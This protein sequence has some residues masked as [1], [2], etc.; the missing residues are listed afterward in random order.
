MSQD[1]VHLHVHSEFSLLDGLSKIKKLIEKTKEYDQ[2]A[3]GLTDH[4]S[5][6]GAINFY[7]AA[8][9]EEIKPIIGCEAYMASE[10]RFDKKRSDAYHILLLA[11]DKEGYE[12]LMKL[13][14]ISYLDGFYYKPRIDKE[15]LLKYHKGIIATTGCPSSLVNRT[16]INEGYKQG[17]KEA[18]E[19]SQIFGKENLFIELQRHHADR[20]ITKDMPEKIKND[21]THMQQQNEQLENHLLKLS[22]ELSLPLI[23]TN[24]VHYVNKED[25]TAQD[26]VVCVQTGKLVSEINRMR[27]IDVPDYYLKSPEEM[28][29]NFSDLPEAI[30]NTGKISDRINLEI[31][32]GQWFFPKYKLPKGKTAGETLKELSYSGAKDLFKEVTDELKK[33]LDYELDIIETK[34]YSP[35]FLIYSDLAKAST[36]MGIY[37]NTRGSAAGSLVSYCCGITTVDPLRFDLPFERFLN[38]LRPSAPDIDFDVSDD[39][40]DLIIHYLK[41]KYGI[42]KVAQICTF[43]TMKA[44]AAIRDIGRVLGY[45]YSDVDKISKM[46]PEGKQGFPMSL[47]RALQTTPE[48]KEAYDKDETTKKIINLSKTVEGNVRHISVHA[49]GVV[50][51]PEDMN[52]FAPTQL[53]TSTKKGE[54]P[55]IITQYEMHACEDVGLVKLDIL[56]IRNL[57]ILANAIEIINKNRTTPLDIK[58][59]PLDDPKTFKLFSDGETFGVFQFASSGM[60][61]HLLELKPE[62]IEDIMAMVALYRPGPMSSIPEYIRRKHNP[63]LITYLDPRMEKFLKKS[64]GI[65]VYQ[66]DVLYCAMELSG[67]DWGEV[68]KFRK[69]IGKKIPEE[70]EKQKDRFING[71]I[72]RGMKKETAEELF[73]QIETFAA[74]GFNKA[75][76]ASYGMVAY[77]TAYTKA[78][79]PVQYM[80]S[81]MTA[82]ANNTDKLTEAISAT[83]KLGIRILP[84]DI[85]ES[86]TNFTIVDLPKEQWL[87]RG[88]AKNTGKAI[89]F[90]FSAIK[91]VGA[92]AIDAIVAGRKDGPFTSFTDFIFRVNASKVNK[93]VVE[94]LI[95]SGTL[96]RFGKRAA[97][98]S[99]LPDLKDKAN[100]A[101]KDKATGQAGLFTNYDQKNNDK[102]EDKLPDIEE[103]PLAEKLKLEKKLLGFYLTDN[104]IKQIV[105]QIEHKVSHKIEEISSS[106]VGQIVTLGGILSSIR[107]VNTKKNNSEMA[108]ASLEDTSGSIDLVIFPKLY[109]ETKVDIELDKG[110]LISGRVD[111]KDNQLSILVETITEI[112]KEHTDPKNNRDLEIP[113]DTP[114]E[115]LVKINSILKQNSPGKHTVTIVIK[116]GGPPKLIDLPYTVNLTE[117]LEKKIKALL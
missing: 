16:M 66:D 97:L 99:V 106:S 90:G 19:L 56:G 26:A 73:S 5:M 38:P 9:K 79:Y 6:Y 8:L 27:Y 109:Q 60:T 74:Y 25:A 107:V 69:A 108:F 86:E 11:E 84:P 113:R 91:N 85:N 72:E 111:N 59:V 10:S 70:M 30:T 88:R 64:K 29:T 35:Y 51:S 36:N 15:T 37:V 82:E 39:K 3:I 58:K 63:S 76:A 40:R 20:F 110:V 53:E 104:P 48:L 33:R 116:N 4:G 22:K 71:C 117:T 57:S 75:H 55:K 42:S 18:K 81:L 34:G 68:D 95:Y 78:N 32:L 21:L 98:L 93:K 14:S 13:V 65:L 12:N 94:S 41:D 1:F 23:A 2:K 115:T 49:A 112:K 80:T 92:A 46:I 105:A 102:H 45:P 50:I 89:R 28:K 7:K 24:D 114:K 54:T 44:K 100:K 52:K 103:F 43:G 96:D 77:W 62:I 31:I 47:T 87:V 83:E 17:L 101:A 67:Y 61:K